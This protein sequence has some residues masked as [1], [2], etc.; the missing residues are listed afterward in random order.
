MVLLI[1]HMY[2]T[3]MQVALTLV[4][5][6]TYVCIYMCHMRLTCMGFSGC[7]YCV[8]ENESCECLEN[9]INV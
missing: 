9:K 2:I 5:M 6:H 1:L 3:Q 8:M 4:S 7:N